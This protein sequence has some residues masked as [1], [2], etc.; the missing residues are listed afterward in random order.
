VTTPAGER[1]HGSR[2]P[3]QKR[4]GR[5]APLPDGGADTRGRPLSAHPR[6]CGLPLK[7][8]YPSSDDGSL[9]SGILSNRT[10]PVCLKGLFSK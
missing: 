2:Q 3:M 7:S 9:V 8:G 1:L 4:F 5:H 6:H 10:T